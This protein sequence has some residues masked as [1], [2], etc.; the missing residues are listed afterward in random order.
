MNARSL[1]AAISVHFITCD[2]S[3]PHSAVCVALVA[4]L[5]LALTLH[6]VAGCCCLLF[7]AST[8]AAVAAIFI[9]KGRNKALISANITTSLCIG[10]MG[11]KADKVLRERRRQMQ[12]LFGDCG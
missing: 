3:R 6:I 10:S 8:L 7:R 4:A 9:L 12:V 5:L 11:K 2:G 1:P